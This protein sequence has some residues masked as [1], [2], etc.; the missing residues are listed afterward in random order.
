MTAYKWVK[1]VDLP[2]S[3]RYFLD[4]LSERIAV[5]DR[6]GTTPDRTDDG[7]LWLDTSRPI[8]LGKDWLATIPLLHLNGSQVATG[9]NIDNAM[10]VA[11]KFGMRVEPTRS[12]TDAMKILC[13][14][15][16]RG[17]KA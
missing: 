4:A 2:R 17:D 1:L 6:S 16:N 9:D 8:V 3:H 11:R 7:V 13:N 15:I 12:A 10:T 14:A 5:A